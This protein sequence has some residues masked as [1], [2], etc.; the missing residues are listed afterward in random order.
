MNSGATQSAPERPLRVLYYIAYFQRMAGA[1]RSLF[2]L[3]AHLPDNV[4]PLV[5]IAGEGRAAE[6]FRQAGIDV[7]VMPPGSSLNQFGKVMLSW[8]WLKRAQV[9]LT[10]LLPYTLHCLA[11]M[12]EWQPDIVHV[13]CSRGNLMIG[14]AARLWGCPIVGHMRVQL[15]FKGISQWYFE[16]LTHRIITVCDAIQQDLSPAARAKA[17][18]IYGGIQTIQESRQ[19]PSWLQALKEQNILIVACFASVVPFKG[20]HHLLDAV[21]E[22]NRRG[23]GDRLAVFCVGDIEAEYQDYAN[24]LMR[25]L[26]ALGIH[27]VTFTGWQSNPFP[28]Y[29]AAD[30]EVLPSVTQEVLDYGDKTVMVKGN[31]GFPRTH[32]EAMYFGLPVVGTDI[33]GVREQI[34]D[35][36]NG[37]VVPPADALALADALERLLKDGDLRSRMGQAG[38]DLVQQT[39]STEAH[40]AGMVKVYQELVRDK[41]AQPEAGADDLLESTT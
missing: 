39:F 37:W 13:N 40:V 38:R 35:G 32:L 4:I 2:E 14:A 8:S 6:A 33:A 36:V 1:N 31:E 19:L 3:I 7:A 34:T 5:V 27:N 25:K 20:Q 28:F 11:L 15:A 41:V 26:Q 10:E 24:F 16:Q 21:A 23:W 30:V 22:L 18:T 29:E 9:T 17:K 12:R